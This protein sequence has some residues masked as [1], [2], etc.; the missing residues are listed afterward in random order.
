MTRRERWAIWAM[1]RWINHGFRSRWWRMIYTAL[2]HLA[3]RNV[4]ER[5]VARRYWANRFAETYNTLP[6]D[7]SASA[8]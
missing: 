8:Q 3:Y 6:V 2:W 7:R 1:T 5:E 4:S